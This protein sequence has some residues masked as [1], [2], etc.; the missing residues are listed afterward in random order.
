MKNPLDKRLR[1]FF[2][3]TLIE[4]LENS[5]RHFVLDDEIPF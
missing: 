3:A 2:R 1:D 5:H 4:N